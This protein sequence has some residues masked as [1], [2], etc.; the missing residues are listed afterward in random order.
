MFWNENPSHF[1]QASLFHNPKSIRLH[2]QIFTYDCY[3][4]T[5]T[6]Y[7]LTGTW[8]QTK[9]QTERY[10]CPEREDQPQK[11]GGLLICL[12]LR[13]EINFGTMKNL[14]TIF[15]QFTRSLPWVSSFKLRTNILFR[16]NIKAKYAY[17]KC[18]Q[19]LLDENNVFTFLM[20]I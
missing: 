3:R 19:N 18:Y 13:V 20:L 4:N 12:L 15:L 1:I 6:I 14:H 17:N 11:H 9:D 10:Q 2:C 8:E 16:R 5:L 7:C